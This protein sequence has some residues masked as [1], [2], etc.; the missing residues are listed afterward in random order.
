MSN[1]RAIPDVAPEIING[2]TFVPIRF[3][4]ENFDADVLWDE[5]VKKVTV[6]MDEH[7]IEFFIGKEEYFVDGEK[8]SFSICYKI[9]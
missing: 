6:L 7:K 4:T 1:E 9:S 3:V 2:T 8:L 5:N